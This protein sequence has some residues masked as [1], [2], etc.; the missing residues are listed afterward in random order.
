[1][2]ELTEDEEE[3]VEKIL[4]AHEETFPYLTD[5][6]KYRL[7]Q[8]E[9]EKGNVILWERVSELSTKAIANVVD[10]GKQV[11][12]FTQLSTNDQ[13]T[14]LKAACLEI[15]I[16]RLASRYDDKEDT[17]SFSNGLTLT[18]QQ[19]EVG[20]FGTLTPTIFK[21]ARSLVE[22]SVD[23]A[24]YAMLS[25]ICLI[26]GDRSGLE[27]PEKVEQKQEPILETLK[28]YVRKRRPD[29]PHSFAKLLL[30]LTDLRSLSVKGAERV[31]QLRMEMPGELP[32][33]ILEMLDRTE[34]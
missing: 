14:L 27:H 11:P 24:E 7:T 33:L 32:P 21:F 22:L 30:K 18:Q 20:G 34:N 15:I 29:S 10:F 12:V 25:L 28:H 9:L 31:L 16:L 5:D 26:S 2:S 4:K 17:M 23:T 8:E 19:L 13:I 1:G 3:M 6:D